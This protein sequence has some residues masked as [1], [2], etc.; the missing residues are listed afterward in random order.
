VLVS[1]IA[2]GLLCGCGGNGWRARLD[3]RLAEYGHRNWVAVIDSAYPKQSA[4]DIETVVTGE[5]HLEVLEVVLD[6][7][8]KAPHVQAIVMHDAELASVA[9]SDAPGIADYRNRLKNLLKGRQVKV[10]PHEQII[11]RLDESSK[12]FNV[13][14]LKTDMVLPY[15]SVFVEL[16]CG[17]WGPQKEKRLRDAIGRSK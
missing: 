7:I 5:D 8:E 2:V 15:T 12:M 1:V 9:D 3:G 6:K 17:Y 16:D 10:M 11:A 4:A 14:L 13:L